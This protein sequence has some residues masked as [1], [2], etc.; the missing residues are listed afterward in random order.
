MCLHIPTKYNLILFK[1]IHGCKFEL[2]G[3]IIIVVV[4]FSFIEFHKLA[5]KEKIKRMWF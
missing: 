3:D 4:I 2:E 1:L 5:M